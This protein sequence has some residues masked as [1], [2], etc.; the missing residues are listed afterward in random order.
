MEI[1]LYISLIIFPSLGVFLTTYIFLKKQ[2]DKEKKMLQF[3]LKKERQKFFLPNRLESYQRLVLFLERIHPNSLVMRLHNPAY[4]AKMMQ[5]ELLKAIREEF[6]HNVA[7][8]L[9]VSIQSWEMV[10]K[11]KEETIKI[12]NIAGNQM[13][14][15]ATSTDLSSKIFEICNEVGQLPSEITIEFLKKEFQEYI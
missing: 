6:E 12:I 13:G 15:I 5:S 9:F 14:T 11:S 7:Q 2:E 10:K 4:P 3:D 8:Q 1:L